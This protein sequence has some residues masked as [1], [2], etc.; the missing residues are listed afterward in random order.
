[1]PIYAI[2]IVLLAFLSG[3]L[4]HKLENARNE[5]V[6]LL[7]KSRLFA[8]TWE[9]FDSA[10]DARAAIKQDQ[11]DQINKKNS[12]DSVIYCILKTTQKLF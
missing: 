2:I 8:N 9:I 5:K 4:M 1:M 3:Y 11:K 12:K 7:V 6:V 10:V